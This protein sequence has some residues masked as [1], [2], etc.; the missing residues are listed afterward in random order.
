MGV[1]GCPACN[2]IIA[3]IIHVVLGIQQHSVYLLW[4]GDYLWLINMEV[5]Q[6]QQ[7]LPH[8]AETYSSPSWALIVNAKGHIRCLHSRSIIL[9][10]RNREVF[11]IWVQPK[12]R[13]QINIPVGPEYGVL[14][15]N[16]AHHHRHMT[17]VWMGH[18]VGE[19]NHESLSSCAS[20]SPTSGPKNDRTESDHF[21]LGTTTM[22]DYIIVSPVTEIIK[23]VCSPSIW[24]IE[25]TL[26]HRIWPHQL[27]IRISC[28]LTTYP[29]WSPWHTKPCDM[30]SRAT[31]SGSFYGTYLFFIKHFC[32]PVSECHAV[33]V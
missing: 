16:W 31:G 9:R 27:P 5:Q 28:P 8:C 14:P 4:K 13:T 29:N 19:I 6:K 20:S 17:T 30:V 10:N 1:G 15:C 33:S 22:N 25:T 11:V 26:L 24:W 21:Q 18:D 2:N 12:K 32:G 3:I 23:L 7:S